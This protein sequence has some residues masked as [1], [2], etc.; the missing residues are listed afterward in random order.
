M[1][2]SSYTFYV[3]SKSR[4]LW[5]KWV[6]APLLIIPYIIFIPAEVLAGVL[7]KYKRWTLEFKQ[8]FL[9]KKL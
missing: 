7:A 4:T 8:N 5:W 9:Y 3:R 6:I 2:K 1:R